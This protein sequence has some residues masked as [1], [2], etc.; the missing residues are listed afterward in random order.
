MSGILPWIFPGSIWGRRSPRSRKWKQP[1]PFT[2]APSYPNPFNTTTQIRY[3]LEES[4]PVRLEIRS[5]AGQLLRVLVDQH[6]AAGSY[7]V[8]WDGLDQQSRPAGSGLYLCR[9]SQGDKTEARKLLL[10]R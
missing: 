6:Q 7:Q 2:L 9:L 1:L 10:L 3:H 5:L 8:S 4:G